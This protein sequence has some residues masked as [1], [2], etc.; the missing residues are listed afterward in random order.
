MRCRA[1][2]LRGAQT[3]SSIVQAELCSPKVAPE[4]CTDLHNLNRPNRLSWSQQKSI[5]GPAS[6]RTVFT[7]SLLKT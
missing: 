7:L 6:F 5:C 4:H 1:I 3:N 2:A